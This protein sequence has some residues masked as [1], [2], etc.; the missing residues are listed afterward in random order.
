MSISECLLISQM[1]L[2]RVI[3]V[4][5]FSVTVTNIFNA[6]YYCKLM[7]KATVIIFLINWILCIGIY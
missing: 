2:L 3:G 4:H 6:N 5:N 7:P 1:S